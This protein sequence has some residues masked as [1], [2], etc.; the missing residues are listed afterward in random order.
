MEERLSGATGGPPELTLPRPAPRV[1][2]LELA[3]FLFLVLPSMALSFFAVRQG[4]MGFV[5]VAVATILRDLALLSLVLFFLWRNRE[6]LSMIG[7]TTRGVRRD[8]GLGL[9]LF[10]PFLFGTSL[11]ES[12]LLRA[13]FT[14]PSTPGP[15]LFDL[16]GRREV[17]LAF[18]LVLV[19]AI[20]EES[21]FRGY[22]ILRLRAIT[23]RTAI[24]VMVSSVIFSVGHGYEGSAGVVT[25][26]VMG[27][28]FAIIYLWR[29]SLTAP[30]VL[31]FLQDFMSILLL[32]L[33]GVK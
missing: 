18:I 2:A 31:H 3:A 15:S 19:V 7:W 22:L 30:I 5:L 10:I 28:V 6:P 16:A 12:A 21:I 20:T 1:Q 26:G 13:G 9:L 8:I 11:L 4:R 24:A 23:G 27:C 14:A 29:G 25:V 32:P 17:P 33:L